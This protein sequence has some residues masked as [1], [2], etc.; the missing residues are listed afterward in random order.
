MGVSEEGRKQPNVANWREYKQGCSQRDP[1]ARAGPDTFHL[2]S[3][4]YFDT[5]LNRAPYDS[6]DGDVQIGQSLKTS[7]AASGKHQTTVA[8]SFAGSSRAFKP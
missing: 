3:L 8:D 6:R 2:K 7:P 5:A 1:K 4:S